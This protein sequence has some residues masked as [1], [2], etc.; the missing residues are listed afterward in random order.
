MTGDA[1]MLPVDHARALILIEALGAHLD[2]LD[3]MGCVADATV[4]RQMLAELRLIAAQVT[5]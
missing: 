2:T 5:R 4:A 3:A 1:A